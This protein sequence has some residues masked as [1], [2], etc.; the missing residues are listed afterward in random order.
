MAVDEVVQSSDPCLIDVSVS[1]NPY[2]YC[3]K[4]MVCTTSDSNDIV[5]L[6]FRK[7]SEIES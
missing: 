3:T 7:A 4:A 6:Q 1:P 5:H 2:Q